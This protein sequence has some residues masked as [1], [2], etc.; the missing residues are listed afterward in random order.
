MSDVAE[1]ESVDLRG[2]TQAEVRERVE[3]GR[4]NAVPD[5]PVRSLGEIVRANV[6]TRINAIIGTLFVLILGGIAAVESVPPRGR[7]QACRTARW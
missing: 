7:V 3:Q 5:A 1:A 2:L 6:F 4:V